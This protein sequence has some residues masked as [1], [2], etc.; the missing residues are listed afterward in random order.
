[1]EGRRRR[2]RRRR[3]RWD[4]RTGGEVLLH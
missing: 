4:A 2:R 3:R 1:V